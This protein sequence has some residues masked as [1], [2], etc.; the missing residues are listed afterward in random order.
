MKYK[1]V[2]DM[3]VSFVSIAFPFAGLP[4]LITIWYYKDVS[5]VSFWT[6]FL[7]LLFTI[8]LIFYNIEKKDTKMIFMWSFWIIIYIGVLL[9]L[10]I[11]R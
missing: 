8:P 1:T 6:W 7:F 5:G 11:Y 9:G 2:L 4:Q 10:Y 3:V